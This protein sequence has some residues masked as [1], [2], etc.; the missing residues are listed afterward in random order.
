MGAYVVRLP[1]VGRRRDKPPPRAPLSR[2]RVL[3]AALALADDAGLQGVTMRVLGQRLQ[4]EAMSLYK[5]VRDKDDVKDGLI[6]LVFDEVLRPQPGT[7]WREAMRGRARSLRQVILRHPWAA[8]LIE[9]RVT[10][11]PS[12]LRH[13]E[14][15][16][17]ALRDDGFSVGLAY[18][19]FLTLDSYIYGYVMQEVSW[20]FEADERDDVVE[21]LRPAFSIAEHPRMLEIMAWVQARA[22][23]PG[24]STGDGRDADFA[25]GLELILDGLERA[26]ASAPEGS[27]ST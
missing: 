7:P 15:V 20:P 2:E 17:G 22:T 14:S 13:H 4:V 18:S 26:R 8:T 23:G 5:H 11:G 6:E 9:S 19:A 12:R 1:M 24:A 25:F 27:S 16:L 21:A 10:P 3:R